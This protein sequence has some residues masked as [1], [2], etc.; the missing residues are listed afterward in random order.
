MLPVN[1]HV[2]RSDVT[3]ARV[4]GKR[5]Y[6]TLYSQRK[7]DDR[8][9]VTRNSNRRVLL[10]ACTDSLSFP[11]VVESLKKKNVSFYILLYV[12]PQRTVPFTYITMSKMVF[13][14]SDR[15]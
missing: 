15:N 7:R 4:P 14:F 6:G 12:I 10:F 3:F 5:F 2:A 8:K 9:P 11:T 13:F 1:V